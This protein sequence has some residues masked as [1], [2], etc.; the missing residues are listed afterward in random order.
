M[1]LKYHNTTPETSIAELTDEHFIIS[2]PQ[3]V[4]DMFGDLM[5]TNCDRVII[6]ERSLHAD[7]FDL[8]TRLA[9]EI[10]QK[11]SNYRVTLAVVGD[12]AKYDS[13]SLQDFISESNKSN[14]V[15]FTD[16]ISSAILRL[17]K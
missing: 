5:A 4:L 14:R 15:F 1:E 10:L 3:Q 17:E 12:F 9:G 8:R 6:H 7:F 2:E 16:T 11:F 13:K